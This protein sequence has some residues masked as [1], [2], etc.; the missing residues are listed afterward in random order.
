MDLRFRSR[1]SAAPTTELRSLEPSSSKW[2]LD[3]LAEIEAT[4]A[5]TSPYH[6]ARWL[7]ACALSPKFSAKIAIC[8]IDSHA[9]VL[10]P[11]LI[12]AARLSLSD[13]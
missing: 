3:A 12:Y 8:R 13:R 2:A 6:D 9:V 7:A 1:L 5:K 11:V 4:G 10:L